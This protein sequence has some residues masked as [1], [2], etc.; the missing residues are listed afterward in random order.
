M[1]PTIT[2]IIVAILAIIFWDKKINPETTW[3]YA[4]YVLSIVIIYLIAV[5][6]F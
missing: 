5:I 3:I 6:I 4:V 1:I 2:V